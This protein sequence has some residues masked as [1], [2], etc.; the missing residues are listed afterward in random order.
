LAN[1]SCGLS[2]GSGAGDW[3]L[4]NIT[5]LESLIDAERYYPALPVGHPFA[6]VQSSNYWSSSTVASF[7][8][9]AWDV[10]VLTSWVDWS[11][12]SYNYYV[13]PVRGG[14]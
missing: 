12:K 9:Y 3:R 10:H 2:D 5:E 1:G 14:Q 8:G 13:W 7:T 4:P 6:G 11:S